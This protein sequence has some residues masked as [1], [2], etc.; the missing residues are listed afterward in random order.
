MK[1]VLPGHQTV[2][3]GPPNWSPL[4]PFSSTVQPDYP[5]C[6]DGIREADQCTGFQGFLAFHSFRGGTGS[7]FTSL[8]LERLSVD[9]GKK[10]KLEFS[11]YPAPQVSTAVVEPYNSVLTTHTTLKHSDCAFMFDNK[12]I[13]DICPRNLDIE[14]PIYSTLNRLISQ[15]VSF[16]TVSL[17]F[18][19]NVDMTE[20]HDMKIND[21]NAPIFFI[22]KTDQSH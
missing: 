16:T 12:A 6:C 10:S 9:Y 1:L 3:L 17:Q 5:G 13:Y 4:L 20:F 14:R 22:I 8:L 15:I 19:L 7:D 2:Y 11:I 18:A 21:E